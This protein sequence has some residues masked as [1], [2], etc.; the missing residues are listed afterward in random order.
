MTDW[1]YVAFV[2]FLGVQI[3]IAILVYIDARRLGLKDPFVWEMGV[4][5]PAAGIP[6][7]LYYLSNRKTLRKKTE[8]E[9]RTE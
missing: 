1:V 9:P 7:I 8:T 3:P 4:L 6:V 2:A 5:V